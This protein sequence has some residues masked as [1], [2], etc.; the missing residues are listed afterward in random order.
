MKEAQRPS[1]V[2]WDAFDAFPIY[3]WMFAPVRF[4]FVSN[5]T[6]TCSHVLGYQKIKSLVWHKTVLHAEVLLKWFY[7]SWMLA[8][9]SRVNSV[10]GLV[11]LD[12]VGAKQALDIRIHPLR[13]S[14]FFSFKHGL[15]CSAGRLQNACGLLPAPGF[16]LEQSDN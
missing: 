15:S 4:L 3:F 8:D 16:C 5:H 13:A 14:L 7:I 11:I 9:V 2:S 10:R 12:V 6:L 1:A